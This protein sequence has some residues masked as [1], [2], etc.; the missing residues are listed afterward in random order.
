[1]R[2]FLVLALV[3]SALAVS[4]AEYVKIKTSMGDIDVELFDRQAPATVKNFLNY[5]DKGFYNGTIF[6]RVI[7]DFMV[8]GG[9]FD[10][11]FNQKNT[12]APVQNEADNK[13]ANEKGTLAM[14]RTND[15]HSATAQFFINTSDNAFLNH[16][17]KNSRGWGYCVFGKVIKG[18]EVVEKIQNVQ[19]GNRPPHQDVPVKNVTIKEIVRYTPEQTE[20]K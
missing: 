4:A 18:M 2:I 14:A 12:E 6:H 13:I 5:A 10:E 11:K 1:M 3:M 15:P 9:G 19:T 20:N 16:T 17:G 7:K 8:Q